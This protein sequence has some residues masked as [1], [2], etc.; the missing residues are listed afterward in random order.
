M[1]IFD[2]D[3]KINFVDDNNVMV[4]YDTNQQCCE[5]A[6]Y[7]FSR[8]PG[9]PKIKVTDEQLQDYQFDINYRKYVNYLDHDVEGERGDGLY[10]AIAFRLN[11]SQ[12][13]LYLMLYNC[14]NGYYSHGFEMRV[15]G[16]VIDDG[17]L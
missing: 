1:K 5:S 4:G 15:N 16:Q 7:Y 11:S 6:Y 12:K 3:T 14:H 8:V 10:S 17:R 2:S 9:G 13:T